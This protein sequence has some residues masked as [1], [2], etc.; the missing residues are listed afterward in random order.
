MANAGKPRAIA[1]A[2]DQIDYQRFDAI[3]VIDADTIIA[4]DFAAQLSRVPQLRTKA[5]QAYHGVLNP[6]DNALTRMAAVFAAAR[7]QFEFR[8]KSAAGL[9]VPLMGNGMC[10]G[11]DVLKERGWTAFSICED[12]ELY[13]QLTERGVRIDGCPDARLYSQEARS[14]RQSKSQRRRWAAGKLDVAARLARP[15]LV[16]NKIGFPQKLDVLAELLAVGPAVHLGI[17]A[18]LLFVAL[19]WPIPGALGLSVALLIPV[20]R[21][22]T[23]TMAAVWVD[24]TPARALAAFAFLPFY[25][26]WRFYVQLSALR[27]LG[28]QPWVRTERHP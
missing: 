10:I 6:T 25:T 15:L 22:S 27:M 17:T 7:Y 19:Y 20:V 9:N 18:L 4:S 24:P 5:V 26:A 14:L 8:L 11:T 28:E 2:L 3:V 12:W 1:W 23:Y 13:A 16:S 21:L